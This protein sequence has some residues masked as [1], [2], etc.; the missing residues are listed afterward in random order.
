MVNNPTWGALRRV[1]SNTASPTDAEPVIRDIR[2]RAILAVLLYHGL[3][4]VKMTGDLQGNRRAIQLY[5]V[6]IYPIGQPPMDHTTDTNLQTFMPPARRAEQL[7]TAELQCAH[8]GRAVDHVAQARTGILPRLHL[9]GVHPARTKGT[10]H[11]R[12][13][14]P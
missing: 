1:K 5:K 9:G 12:R 7:K 8:I 2:D 11:R 6:L 14:R 3:R 4:R 10:H 13:M